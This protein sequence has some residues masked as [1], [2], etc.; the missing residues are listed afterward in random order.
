MI[1]AREL[2][3]RRLDL[4]LRSGRELRKA[5]QKQNTN[6]QRPKPMECKALEAENTAKGTNEG[7]WEVQNSFEA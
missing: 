1:M 3:G 7:E 6:L 5:Q 2:R 4:L